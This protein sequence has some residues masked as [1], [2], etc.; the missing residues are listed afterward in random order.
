MGQQAVPSACCGLH[1]R[2]FCQVSDNQF[3]GIRDSIWH[4]LKEG[5]ADRR[6]YRTPS[7]ENDDPNH[8]MPMVDASAVPDTGGYGTLLK[9]ISRK[10]TRYIETFT[11]EGKGKTETLLRAS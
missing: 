11:K 6:N 2:P 3:R 5:N 7:G 10:S 9:K 4:H 8:G 1:N